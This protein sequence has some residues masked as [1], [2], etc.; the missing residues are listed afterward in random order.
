MLGQT[1]ATRDEDGKQ[2]DYTLNTLGQTEGRAMRAG[3]ER[4]WVL[5]GREENMTIHDEGGM[6][7]FYAEW[8]QRMGRKAFDPY[9]DRKTAAVA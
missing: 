2:T 7:H 3:S 4:T 9:G 1:T 8:S 6:R 5:H